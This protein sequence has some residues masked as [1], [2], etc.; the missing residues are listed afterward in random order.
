MESEPSMHDL[1]AASVEA[2]RRRERH[3]VRERER[4]QAMSTEERENYLARRRQYYQTR[5]AR[6]ASIGTVGG[7][8]RAVELNQNVDTNFVC[9]NE[10]NNNSDDF[11]HRSGLN[12]ARDFHERQQSPRLLLPTPKIC[13]HCRAKLFHG[14][15]RNFCCNGG[16]I[17]LPE[18]PVPSELY[19]LFTDQSAEGRIFRQNIRAFNHI[20]SFTSL[21][22]KLDESVAGRQGVYT[23]RAHGTMYH[24][25]G[26]LLPSP[27]TR[28]RYIQMFIYDTEH[29]IE[30][31][32][33]ENNGLDRELVDKIKHILD[34]HN[35]FV[36][37]LRQLAQRDDIL[38]CK[39]LIKER[40]TA[41]SR[42]ALPTASQV[43]AIIVGG[44]EVVDTNNRDIIVQTIGGQLM[45]VKEFSGYYDP[46]QYPLLLPYGTYGW[47]SDC[48]TVGGTRVT[49]CDYYAYMLQIETQKLR[50]IRTHQQD[51]RAEL[52]QGLQ[53]CLNAGED[54]AGNVGRRTILPSSF[55][56]SP[57]DMYQRYQDAMSV[58]QKFGKPNLFITM[59]CNPSWEEIQNELKPGQTPQD[60]PD[61][62]TR[63]FRA[64]FEELKKDVYTKGVLG[65]VVA[66]V[67]VIEYQ[68]RGLPHAHMLVIL[69]ENDKLNTP[70]D[71][72]HIVRA[73]IPDKNDEPMLYEAVMRHMI[74]GP[75]GEMNV[76]APCM[77]NGT[78][79][80]NYPKPF[81]QCTIQ[82][83]DSYPIYRRRDDNRS[84]ALDRNCDVVVDNGWVVILIEHRRSLKEFDLPQI[85]EDYQD[86]RSISSLI[87]DELSLPIPLDDLNA[88][89]KLNP[90]QLQAFNTIKH[91][92]MRKQS[93]TFFIDGPGG[94]GKTFLYRVLLANFRNVGLIIVATATSGIAAI[95][96][97][98]GR[99]AHS[100]LKI[101]IKLDSSSRCNF[102]KQSEPFGGKIM[103]LGGDFRQVVPVV[104]GGTR[105]QAV[106]ASIV[107]S[108]L[109]YSIK[110]LHLADNIRA[111]N[112]QSF[113]DFLLRIG[114]GEE[115]TVEDNMIRI[116]DS[117]AISFEGEHSIHDLIESTFPDL[118]SHTYDHEYMMDR[119]LITPLNDDV[120]KLNERVLQIFTGEEEVTYYS[121]DSVSEDMNNL[122]LPEFLNSLSPGNLPPHKLT[123]KKGAPIM[124][125]RNIDP[126]IGLCNGTRLICRRF[127]RN[128]VD[129]EILTGQFKGL[130]V[131][132]PRIPLKTSEDAK[133]PFEMM[134]RQFPVRLSFA[135]TINKSQG[136]TIPND[137]IYLP[138]HVFSHGQLYVA[139][140]RGISE[141]TT[142]VLVTKG[143]INGIE[144]TYTRNVVFQ[145]IFTRLR[146]NRN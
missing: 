32:L 110:V 142:K 85:A 94:T 54:E 111:Q 45:N 76:N 38:D 3:R 95:Q 86:L 102:S 122:Y 36:Q 89:S 141:R 57:R 47:D 71:Y 123:L 41:H 51:I 129:A 1:V 10:H 120:N 12:C 67:H 16:K 26:T 119:A 15:T 11:T 124:L 31:R 116:P 60:R 49:C 74:H 34:A 55:V 2:E 88:V 130:R 143:K 137:G 14:E 44:D 114:N 93:Q 118:G 63:I 39:L 20:F 13:L 84:I 17:I 125:L 8:D 139:L 25:I 127:G 80:K 83:T 35:P 9:I 135:L 28:P 50:F 92:I 69:D 62:L 134:R 132:L 104:V 53:D 59:T 46:L 33:L 5:R 7:V 73:E 37:T 105:S 113:S 22:A 103:I 43:A 6:T 131:F 81:A 101:P 78:C 100:K 109:W 136:Q 61:L 68:K 144:G 4:R 126:K 97:P 27:G 121:F 77:K 42:Y 23:F 40:P 56:G 24:K 107:E 140:S 79:K 72:D 58:V 96:L 75:C 138:D 133:M 19:H 106:K 115:P 112:D 146:N 98:G 21:G 65:K 29:E 66:H 64:K 99:T 52:Y 117:M 90:S 128:V 30:N 82:G 70:D 91:A 18:I 87:E 48:R 145:E 108:H